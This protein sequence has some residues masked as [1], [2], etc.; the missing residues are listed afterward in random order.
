MNNGLLEQGDN[1]G[2][3]GCINET[4]F[5]LIEVVGKDKVCAYDVHVI[6]NS[7]RGEIC[8]PCRG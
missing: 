4:V 3:D 6:I 5:N 2:M 1:M 7:S 8:M